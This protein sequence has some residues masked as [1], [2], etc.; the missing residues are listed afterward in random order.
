MADLN[1]K[2]TDAQVS[3]DNYKRISVNIEG[4]DI[5]NV[6]ENFTIEEIIN[7][8]GEDKL[9]EAIGEDRCKEYFDLKSNDE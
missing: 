7:A 1:F 5:D 2:C 9:L 3:A 8:L 6:L 4:A